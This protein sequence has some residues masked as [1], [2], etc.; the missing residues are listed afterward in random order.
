MSGSKHHKRNIVASTVILTCICGSA[1]AEDWPM[2]GRD[3]ARTSQTQEDLKLPLA[4]A[5]S[6]HSQI[7]PKPIWD[8]PG[9]WD[10]WHKIYNLRNRVDFDKAFHTAIVG[11][12]VWF[13]SSVDDQLYCLDLKSGELIYKFF[14]G[15]P[16]RLAPVV[17][18]G[19]VYFGADD[20]YV[21][22]LRADDGQL[23]WKSRVAPDRL[24]VSGNGRLI[25]KWP[26]R[27]SVAIVDGSC[28]ACAGVF[29]SETVYVAAL[30]AQTGVEQWKTQMNDLPA[31]G[32]LLASPSRLYVFPGRGGPVIFDRHSGERLKHVN[33]IGG[34]Y[35]LL[36]DNTLV[37]TTGR[38][39]RELQAVDSAGGDRLATFA[40]Q[41]MIM[42]GRMSYLQSSAELSAIDRLE[43]I[44]LTAQQ[45]AV[46]KQHGEV[47]E[48]LD[49][50]DKNATE[51]RRPLEEKLTELE[52]EGARIGEEM[53]NCN[54]W[55]TPCES[56]WSLI[57]AGEAL[58]SGGAGRV[59]GFSVKTGEELFN[60]PVEGNVYG[61]AVSNGHLLVSTDRGA[62]HA[63]ANAQPGA[64]RASASG[65]LAATRP[66]ANRPTI[67]APTVDEDS[68]GRALGPF[69]R[70]TTPSQIEVT[71]STTQATPTRLAFGAEGQETM[72]LFEAPES[73]TDH[74]LEIPLNGQSGLFKFQ[75]GGIDRDDEP[76]WTRSYTFDALLNYALPER[77]DSADQIYPQDEQTEL[78]RSAAR[79][80][81][82]QAGTQRGFALVVGAVDGRL[83]AELARE[84][85]MK[86]VI[87][88][89]DAAKADRL[90]EK[91]DSA[92][93]Y[94]W[95]VS[96]LHGPLQEAKIAPY[97]ANLITSESFLLEGRLP[98][99]LDA[100]KSWLRPGG[101]V[102]WLG[103]SGGAAEGRAEGE[104]DA[105]LS[106]EPP[107]SFWSAAPGGIMAFVHRR[108]PLEG[109]RDWTHQY[110]LPDNAACSRDEL[111][112][113]AMRVLWWG[114]PGARPMP[115]RGGR[116]PAPVAA[117]GRLYVQGNRTLFGLDAYN[118]AML[119]ARQ[120]PTMRRANVP[121]DGSNMVAADDR[122]YVAIEDACVGF[123][124]PTGDVALDLSVQDAANGLARSDDRWGYLAVVDDHLIGSA[125]PAQSQYV[126][127]EGEWY[128]EFEE[129][130]VAR[131]ESRALFAVDRHSGKHIWQYQG[132]SVMNSTI[133]VADETVFF[134]ESRSGKQDDGKVRRSLESILSDQHL[135][136]LDV[137][138]G[139]KLWERPFDFS[140]CEY[141]TYLC[142]ADGKLLITGTD[143]DKVYHTFVFAT[144]S[145]AF[146][147]D[148]HAQANKTHH[149]GHLAHPT[150]VQGRVYFNKLVY[151]LHNGEILEKDDFDWHGCG[152]MAASDHTIFSRFEF[153]GMLD[154][155]TKE[156]TEL[157]GLRSSCW[158]NIIPSGGLLLAP[159][160][161]SGCS[162]AHSLQTSVAFIPQMS[163]EK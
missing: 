146:I 17:N 106:G 20:G 78:C 145:G 12:R 61:L 51:Q 127:G 108:E 68:P 105:W 29:P 46:Q 83:A 138:T 150:I 35:A 30:D 65:P 157:L 115:D 140:R 38:D 36:V 125:V 45:R 6:W 129:G 58:I 71:W 101:G 32:Y 139:E 91:L 86:I 88:E 117:A 31:Q 59:T 69:V 39:G 80:M 152:V 81:I 154:L 120:N 66:H 87:L 63:F 77:N 126:A 135:V 1:L 97:L 114:R 96:V 102:V 100:V 93:L 9:V 143:R 37:T 144:E 162:C 74:R 111:I 160:M 161:S 103:A 21:Y 85:D 113:G 44:E 60:L 25:S 123:D 95:R 3:S 41:H 110:A 112:R 89:Q 116:N 40:G 56:G 122:L 142:H 26:V 15:G 22:C 156:R 147:W 18:D 10:G 137:V 48:Q 92:G 70:F 124:G 131:V 52:K 27:T 67:E 163:L 54:E 128:E 2:Y 11:D 94:G 136:A 121:R 149:S 50:L 23:E 62:V 119:W 99:N 8:E 76:A 155:H 7:Q 79:L 5:W 24:Q 109:A 42:D 4:R 34:T 53:K 98:G 90:R 158:L 82:Q 148:D 132:G 75:V 43:Y 133:S 141:M 118:G 47:K 73:V 72:S 107:A 49:K 130:A 55:K 28:Y 159:E 104:L 84:C 151:D 16:I 134:I 33:T 64:D 14:A 19:R 13:G 57:R 153:H